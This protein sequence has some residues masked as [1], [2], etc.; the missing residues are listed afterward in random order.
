MVRKKED[1]MDN[2]A[3]KSAFL[4]AACRLP[5]DTNKHGAHGANLTT[6]N[7]GARRLVHRPAH[8]VRGGCLPRHAVR[9]AWGATGNERKG[10]E[11]GG[12]SGGRETRLEIQ[13]R[14]EEK[15]KKKNVSLSTKK[16]LPK[17][18]KLIPP[19]R[20]PPTQRNPSSCCERDTLTRHTLFPLRYLLP[21]PFP[22][23]RFGRREWEGTGRREPA[24]LSCTFTR[25]EA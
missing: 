5:K 13:K 19:R 14:K 22:S 16:Y 17:K 2:S 12:V 24:R 18:Y 25:T 21:I 11:G 10:W 3:K 7:H 1:G 15:A 8:P 4:F 9:G 23:R 6:P 20:T